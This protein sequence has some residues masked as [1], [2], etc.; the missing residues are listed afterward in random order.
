MDPLSLD[1]GGATSEFFNEEKGSATHILQHKL[2]T[3]EQVERA[4]RFALA[5][6]AWFGKKQKCGS[7]E[8]WFDDR[9]QDVSPDV[10][11]A[12][13]ERLAAHVT[14]VVFFGEGE[15]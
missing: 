14:G 3:P 1:W 10:R 2:S 4:A 13:K 6:V 9:E 8:V 7:Q 5:R 11:K 15:A 12:L